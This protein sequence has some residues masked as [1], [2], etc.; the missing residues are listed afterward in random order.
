MTPRRIWLILFLVACALRLPDVG[1]PLV[2]VDEQMYLLVAQRMWDGAVPYVDIWDRKPIG[3]FLIYIASGVL[4]GDPVVACH[5]L[6]LAAAFATAGLIA[7]LARR[8]ATPA[9]A[10]AAGILYLVWLELLGGRGGQSPVF[11]NLA[12]VV[13]AGL[14]TQ[15]IDG[16]RRAAP[17]AMLFAGIGLQIKPT[18][19]FEGVFFGVTILTASWYRRRSIVDLATTGAVCVAIA[20][21]PTAIAYAT[22][23]A[24]GHA[25]AWWFANVASIFLRRMTP[26]DPTLGRLAGVMAVLSIPALLAIRGAMLQRG[27]TRM[28]LCGWL[29]AATIGWLLVPPYF[30]H[31]A[32]PLL[33][34]FAV[35]SAAALDRRPLRIVAGLAGAG[36][37]LLSGY[38]HWGDRTDSRHRLAA[39]SAVIDRAR[40]QGC[41]FVFQAPPALYSTTGS[42]LPTRYPFPYHLVEASEAGAIG[43]DQDA[44]VAR[45]LGAGPPV[46]AVGDIRRNRARPSVQRVAR[47]LAD[48]YRPIASDLGVTVYRRVN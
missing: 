6:A 32:L 27:R 5:L 12:M 31:Y 14:T 17:L 46:I 44:E 7:R 30:N 9:G 10:L 4:P 24:I 28:L 11:Y 15:A 43:V 16:R 37:L 40:G 22:Y 39:L 13:A 33:V 18:I 8:I 20:L 45:V 36:L 48:H 29:I 38:P 41:L 23:A 25:D 34:P 2:D 35:A 1:N 26:D 19:V 42:C 3:L 47:A 21:V